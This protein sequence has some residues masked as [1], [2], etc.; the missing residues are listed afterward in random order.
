L[1]RRSQ[2][3][4]TF[5]AKEVLWENCLNYAMPVSVGCSTLPDMTCG[6]SL[7]WSWVFFVDRHE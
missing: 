4:K 7:I 5:V 6:C 2:N 3:A 1:C